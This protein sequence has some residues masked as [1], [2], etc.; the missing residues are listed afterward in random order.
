VSIVLVAWQVA[1]TWGSPDRILG[2]TPA[3]IARAGVHLLASGE[4]RTH[5]LVSLAEL[6]LGF[7]LAILVG[8]PLGLAMG[9]VRRLEQALDPLVMAGYSTP[10]VALLPVLVLWLGIGVV[11]K[12]AVAFLGA[13]FPVLVNTQAGVRQLDPLWERAV[14]AFGGR[15]GTVLAKVVLPGTLPAIMGGLRLG[16]GRALIGVIVGEMYVSVAGIGQLL[17][18]YGNAG[19]T[20]ELLALAGLVGIASLAGVQAC[21]AAEARLGPWRRGLDP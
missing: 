6:A 19:R 4:L 11:S 18:V 5:A 21:R 9:R 2:A 12:A 13:V 16:L 7:G 3:E 1:G 20:A 14:R 15:P 10:R 17:S 8:V